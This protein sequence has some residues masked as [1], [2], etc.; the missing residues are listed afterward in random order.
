MQ[1]R[2]VCRRQYRHSQMN[3]KG[4]EWQT[5]QVH[6]IRVLSD[7]IMTKEWA[8]WPWPASAISTRLANELTERLSGGGGVDLAAIPLLGLGWWAGREPRPGLAGWRWCGA[9]GCASK[10]KKAP[11]FWRVSAEQKCRRVRNSRTSQERFKCRDGRWDMGLT[12]WLP[13]WLARA[14]VVATLLSV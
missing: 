9:C 13:F 12:R 4:P 3:Q 2:H 10:G 7:L 11:A 1:L 14:K 8:Q 5:W 6:W